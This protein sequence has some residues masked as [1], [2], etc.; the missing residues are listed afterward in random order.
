ML[1]L[2]TEDANCDVMMHRSRKFDVTGDSAAHVTDSRP[3]RQ[4]LLQLRPDKLFRRPTLAEPVTRLGPATSDGTRSTADREYNDINHL[5][6]V[7]TTE[8]NVAAYQLHPASAA[9]KS[10]VDFKPEVEYRKIQPNRSFERS[11]SL[12]DRW[13]QLNDEFK[14]LYQARSTSPQATPSQG[15]APPPQGQTKVT[16]VNRFKDVDRRF[17]N[18]SRAVGNMSARQLH[19]TTSGLTGSA[20]VTSSKPEIVF[21]SGERGSVTSEPAAR[22]EFP[23][24]SCN[25]N[26]RRS[27]RDDEAVFGYVQS[28]VGQRSLS[29]ECP[30]ALQHYLPTTQIGWYPDSQSTTVRQSNNQR[31]S[32][33][34]CSRLPGRSEQTLVLPPTDYQY[35]TLCTHC[36]KTMTSLHDDDDVI[37]A[38]RDNYIEDKHWPSRTTV[39]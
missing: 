31:Q 17:S 23:E 8:I 37:A 13:R 27:H 7:T 26:S 29:D 11:G 21:R 3:I 28:V 6:A 9:S 34:L 19:N 25:E 12:R 32:S 24:N 38:S 1:Y 22:Q 14:R 5:P 30:I 2:G 18:V 4:S 10:G 20:E 39:S 15:H 33:S 35:K 36:D 16:K